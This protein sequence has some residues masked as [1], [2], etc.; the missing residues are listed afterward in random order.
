MTIAESQAVT[1]AHTIDH[2][3]TFYLNVSRDEIA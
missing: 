3:I 1:P 2:T